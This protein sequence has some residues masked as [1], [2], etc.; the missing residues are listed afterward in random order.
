MTPRTRP[1]CHKPSA[2]AECVFVNGAFFASFRISVIFGVPKKSLQ[3]ARAVEGSAA[4]PGSRAPGARSA[5]APPPALPP[6]CPCLRAF[7]CPAGA[8]DAA[9]LAHSP[10]P[11]IFGQLSK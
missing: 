7:P 8:A 9:L 6:S 4:G 3:L 10:P 11:R 5:D 1:R 2:A